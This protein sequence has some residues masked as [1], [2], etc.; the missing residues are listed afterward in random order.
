MKKK[1]LFGVIDVGASAIRLVIA[2]KCEANSYRLLESLSQSNRLGTDTFLGGTISADSALA[3]VKILKNYKRILKDYNVIQFRL[4]A[5][6]AVREAKN[7]DFFID[8]IY[9]NT[10]LQI[11]TIESEEECKFIFLSSQNKMRE[12]KIDMVA[13]SLLLDL[14]TGTARI[15]SIK[16]QK[17]LSTQSLKLGSL[18]L[19]EILQDIDVQSFEFHKV[20]HAFIKADID[21]LRKFSP[22]PKITRLIIAGGMMDDILRVL[23]PDLIRNTVTSVETSWFFQILDE[24]KS[25]SQERFVEKF[26]VSHDKAD[27]LVPTII[28][29]RYFIEIFNPDEVVIPNS[30]LAE[31]V[32]LNEFSPIDYIDAHILASA[33]EFGKKFGCEESHAQQVMQLC[34]SIFKQT[35]ALHGLDERYLLILKLA[36][37][38]H[39]IGHYVNDQAHH[40][41]SQYLIAA[42]SIIGLTKH[43]LAQV[44]I[45]AR[46]HRRYAIHFSPSQLPEFTSEEKIQLSKLIAIIRIANA[47]DRTHSNSVSALK[48]KIRKEKRLVTFKAQINRNIPLERWAFK[49]NKKLFSK[50]FYTECLLQAERSFE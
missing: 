24:F 11:Q 15:I 36:A 17:M 14:G 28:V 45:V 12:A 19:R 20:L 1:N 6:S 50:L 31:G 10:G 47:L 4:V 32:I 44:A 9:Q 22:F 27:V 25:V 49:Y 8:Y 48:I 43:Q 21:L 3:T 18:R 2:E 26:N 13:P 30:S 37:L 41:H 38:L 40:K 34:E 7:R 23:K 29:Y 35:K 39:D 16:N 42:S 33:I 5:T 46:N